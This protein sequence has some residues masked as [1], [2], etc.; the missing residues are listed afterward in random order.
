MFLCLS[1]GGF[2]SFSITLYLRLP[3]RLLKALSIP[4][5]RALKK[6]PLG[7]FS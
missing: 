4:Q 2:Y 6:S 5:I 7:P 1:I 3:R